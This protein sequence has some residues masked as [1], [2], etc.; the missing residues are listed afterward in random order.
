MAEINDPELIGLLDTGIA[1]PPAF[2]RDFFDRLLLWATDREVSDLTFQTGNFVFVERFGRLAPVTRRRWTAAE[3]YRCA[4]VIYGDNAPSQLAKGKDI[5][6]SYEIRRARNDLARYRV[7]MVS[8]RAPRERGVEITIR[9]IPTT[10]PTLDSLNLPPG[11]RE[12]LIFEQ[13]LV[14][15]TGPVGS[16]KTTLLEAIVR[17]L[18]E[19]RES[20]RKIV[21]LCSPIEYVDDFIQRTHA[22]IARHEIGVHLEDYASGVRGTLRRKPG[23]V[24]IGEARDAATIDAMTQVA[25]T[26]SMVYATTHTNSVPE[27][28]RR[29]VVPFPFH[30]QDLRWVDLLEPLRCVLTQRLVRTTDGLRTPVREFLYFTPAMKDPILAVRPERRTAVIRDF[31][32]KDGQPL[33]VD[34]NALYTAARI[35]EAEYHNFRDVGTQLDPPGGPAADPGGGGEDSDGR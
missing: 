2:D 27:T 29:L 7:H 20:H 9:T 35:S 26:G 33:S 11:L 30:E 12:H 10:A 8:M 22:T 1:E 16:G 24:V 28:L 4:Q 6:C 14:L 21:C 31:V 18:Q 19:L 5:D 23:V 3:T 25:L 34:L 17:Y 15:V 32:R 13:G